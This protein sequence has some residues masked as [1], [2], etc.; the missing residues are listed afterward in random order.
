MTRIVPIQV[1]SM[2]VLVLTGSTT[3]LAFADK[4]TLVQTASTKRKH[5]TKIRAVMGPPV[6]RTGFLTLS[7]NVLTGTRARNASSLS[8]GVVQIHVKTGNASK[9]KT[10]SNVSV[11]LVGLEWSATWKWS[12]AMT[13]PFGKASPSVGYAT[14]ELVRITEKSTN[15][16]AKKDSPAAIVR[17]KLTY[18][19]ASSLA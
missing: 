9:L 4:D 7:V 1:A 16:S 8:I 15:V 12:H 5:A 13:R 17:R 2:V 14:M 10:N 18:V 19:K 3:T 11:N 6:K